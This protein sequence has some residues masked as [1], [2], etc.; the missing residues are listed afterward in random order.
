MADMRNVSA[1][2][3]ALL[4]PNGEP[5]RMIPI[6]KGMPMSSANTKALSTV[7]TVT[8]CVKGGADC[9]EDENEWKTTMEDHGTHTRTRRNST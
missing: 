1:H 2:Q 7:A 4:A 6:R 8:P 3:F 5:V 9:F